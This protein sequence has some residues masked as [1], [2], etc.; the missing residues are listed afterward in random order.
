MN[1]RTF[2]TTLSCLLMCRMSSCA[3]PD[4]KGLWTNPKPVLD[5]IITLIAAG[6]YDSQ[7][8]GAL[9]P[10]LQNLAY[11][12]SQAIMA[13]DSPTMLTPTPEREA[14]IRKWG[15]ILAPYTEKLVPLALDPKTYR[16]H[17]GGESRSVL[18]YAL[19]TESLAHQV[20]PYLKGPKDVP[21]DAA[22][23]LYEHR[24]LREEDKAILSERYATITELEEQGQWAG[25]LAEMGMADGLKY[26][27]QTLLAEPSSKN[28]ETFIDFYGAALKVMWK[29]GPA[30]KSLLPD[31]EYRMA[32]LGKFR[33]EYVS[34]FEHAHDIAA[35]KK[36]PDYPIAR[37]GSG[38]LDPKRSVISAGAQASANPSR[39]QLS[40]GASDQR[41]PG[42]LPLQ[43]SARTSPWMWL[44]IALGLV[45]LA[46]LTK[47]IR[48]RGK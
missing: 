30:A 41:V 18:N 7:E 43:P 8:N 29:L 39:A 25:S 48:K 26:S 6:D 32:N 28:P 14:M 5:G 45:L 4:V 27:K 12:I 15:E 44:L 33:T 38:W 34:H 3:D 16:T 1:L 42:S 31:L 21:L 22:R 47:V 17:A 2:I 13:V 46:A 9:A 35:G 37:N 11:A 36:Q 23:L 24:L 10:A 40:G 19:P 20:R